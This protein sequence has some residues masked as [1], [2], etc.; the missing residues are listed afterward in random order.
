MTGRANG[1]DNPAGG[2]CDDTDIRKSCNDTDIRNTRDE[3]QERS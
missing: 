3:R 1:P 2:S